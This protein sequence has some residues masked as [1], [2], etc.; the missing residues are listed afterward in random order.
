MDATMS[1][2]TPAGRLLSRS[3]LR[4]L[5]SLLIGW[6]LL[7]V[8]TPLPAVT[9]D[10]IAAVVDRQIITVSEISQMTLVRFLP[11]TS[12]QSED[13]YRH[14]IL[15]TLIAQALRFRDVER[16]GARDIPKD[17]IETR[18]QEIEARSSSPAAFAAALVKAEL[19]LD[20][21]R[22]LIKR[23]LQVEA[24]IQERFAPTVLVS[25]DEIEAYYAGA[26]SQQRKERGLPIPPLSDVRDDVRSLI[27]SRQL[28]KEIET[29]TGQLRSHANV[30][31]YAWR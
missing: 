19:S 26:W 24:Y 10:R 30:D 14:E 17:S 20:E 9:V 16:F 11:R 13:D 21:L 23:Q 28:Q 5:P 27:R 4:T 3:C 6:I 1:E 7:L 22:A 29:W 8:A 31:V 2:L 25:S 18:L 12:G 15:D